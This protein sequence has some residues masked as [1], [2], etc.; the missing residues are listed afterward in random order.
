MDAVDEYDIRE[1]FMAL[2][3]QA[4]GR[5]TIDEFYKLYAPFRFKSH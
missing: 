2:D 5:L 1:S 3:G 4:I